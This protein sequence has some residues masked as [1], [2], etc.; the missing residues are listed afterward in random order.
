MSLLV[1]NEDD[2][3]NENDDH[4][5]A[6]KNNHDD[7]DG[8]FVSSDILRPVETVQNDEEKRGRKHASD[9]GLCHKD[10]E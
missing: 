6:D 8:M 10:A 2:N 4:G 1:M 9:D 3:D 5:Y 7:S